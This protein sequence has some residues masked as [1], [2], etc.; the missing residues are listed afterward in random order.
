MK[1]F[2]VLF[3]LFGFFGL[4]A[5]NY[6]PIYA[7]RKPVSER[8]FDT[9]IVDEY[10]WLEDI[11]SPETQKW[12]RQENAMAAR[13]LEAISDMTNAYLAID[14]LR[15]I[16]YEDDIKKGPYYF[17]LYYSSLYETPAL[18]FR[19]NMKAEYEKLLDPK[20]ISD[21]DKIIIKGFEISKDAKYLAVIFGRNGSDWSEIK[22]LKLPS[23]RLLSDHVKGV[24]YSG[25]AWEGNG[26][27]YGTYEQKNKF[28]ATLNNKVF[29]HRLGTGQ[30]EDKLVFRRKNNPLANFE[31]KTTSDERFFIL[32]EIDEKRGYYN[33]FY[34]D[35]TEEHPVLKPLWYKL[36]FNVD[37]LDNRG[38]ELLAVSYKKDQYG[39]GF[40]FSVRQPTVWKSIIPVDNEAILLD[41]VP[42]AD[43]ILA[44]YQSNQ[45]PILRVYDYAGNRLYSLRFPPAVSVSG[46]QGN[47]NDRKVLFY[48][49]SY[50]IP[51]VVYEFDL[52]TF[53]RKLLRKTSVSFQYK[54]IEYKELEY[55]SKD[56]TMVP[57][58]LVYN[59]KIFLSGKNPLILKAYGGFGVISSPSYDP[60][61]VYF[62]EKGGIFA[63]ANIRGGGDKGREWA[64]AGRGKNKQKSFDD[65]IAA[66]EY[67]I[68]HH[69][70]SPEKLAITGASNGGLV[71]AVAAT[72]RPELFKAVV[73]VVAPLDMLRFEKFT[74]GHFHI[75]EYGTVK[76]SASF[77]RLLQYSPYHNIRKNINY[78]ATLV[79]TSENDDRVPPFHSYKFVAKLQN[80][81]QQTNPVL[82]RVYK[83][84][85]HYGPDTYLGNIREK[86]DIFGFIYYHLTK[87]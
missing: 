66:A 9:L 53:E 2:L 32:K 15:N 37:I 52:Y 70:T 74:V 24:K 82:L 43:R 76:D 46:F 27:Y 14:R 34:K 50:T 80:R 10:R 20:E 62:L 26:F 56:G 87:H 6:H 11:S 78:P 22:V 19:K 49:Q 54:D 55:P 29:Y 13:Y 75:D 12:V 3:G 40:T 5:Q 38:D 71:V 17:N 60:G 83:N 72:Q 39:L 44:L 61:I 16:K 4:G 67:L 86:A 85:G 77:R 31:F 35:N 41:I 57:M 68:Q 25:V 73:P 51:T 58:I 30:Q 48:M 42:F 65:F 7:P 1:K 79:V 63:F 36:K 21:T 69:Y 47:P 18:Y 45:H 81:V 84:A 23:G 28:G 59:K 33:I 64:E 8:Y